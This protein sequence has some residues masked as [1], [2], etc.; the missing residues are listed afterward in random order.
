M[1]SFKD[2]EM[3]MQGFGTVG[4]S[5]KE[6][7]QR[8]DKEARRAEDIEDREFRR[9]ERAEAALATAD[10][11][12]GMEEAQRDQIAAADERQKSEHTFRLKTLKSEQAFAKNQAHLAREDKKSE[13]AVRAATRRG[14][15][16]EREYRK[17]ALRRGVSKDKI[18]QVIQEQKE[19]NKILTPVPVPDPDPGSGKLTSSKNYVPDPTSNKKTWLARML[20]GAVPRTS[21]QVAADEAR[22]KQLMYQTNSEISEGM[23]PGVPGLKNPYNKGDF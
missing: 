7:K 15:F 1:P 2:L 5:L 4:K 9:G 13:Q 18:L 3:L 20:T 11:R 22:Q 14:R 12:R 16:N 19:L 10:Y 17:I 8:K 6:R 23:F 21:E